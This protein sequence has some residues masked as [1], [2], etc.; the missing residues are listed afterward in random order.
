LHFISVHQS[1]QKCQFRSEFG[2]GDVNRMFKRAVYC[3]KLESK[4][5]SLKQ[6]SQVVIP[7][8]KLKTKITVALS[9]SIQTTET[10]KKQKKS[11]VPVQPTSGKVKIHKRSEKDAYL[12]SLF[13]SSTFTSSCRKRRNESS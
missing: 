8:T 6:G 11:S 4:I 10:I 12:E 13:F 9:A 7:S 2:K 1:V 3:D 5:S